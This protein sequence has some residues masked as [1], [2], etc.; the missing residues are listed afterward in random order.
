MRSDAFNRDNESDPTRLPFILDVEQRTH[1][2]IDF[3]GHTFHCL[4]RQLNEEPSVDS[5]K[6]I[7]EFD[8]ERRTMQRCKQTEHHYSYEH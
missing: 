6:N 4:S 2:R 5:A 8:V 3:V 7:S 1:T